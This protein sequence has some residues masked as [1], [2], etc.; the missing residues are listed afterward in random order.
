MTM[1]ITQ[2]MEQ[3]SR[4]Y[5]QAIAA[6]AGFQVIRPEVDDDSIDCVVMGKEGRRP[7]LEFQLKSTTQ[8]TLS[9]GETSF[10]FDLSIKNYNDLR[11]DTT[12]PRLLVVLL[13]PKNE[14][15]WSVW[16]EDD[17]RLKKC[18]YWYSLVGLP[19]TDNED[20]VRIH[21]P[22]SQTFNQDALK[23]IMDKINKGESL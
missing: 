12:I 2:K 10:P 11:A 6:H 7:R 5:V 17:L 15:D 3:F 1:S 13:M 22:R 4:A 9:G 14:P 18:A 21:I 16:S 8:V 23:M 19:D 20:S